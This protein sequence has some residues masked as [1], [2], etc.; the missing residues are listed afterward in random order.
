M[1]LQV[2]LRERFAGR[3][4]ILVGNASFQHDRSEFIDGHDIVVRFN[5]FARPDLNPAFRGQRIDYWFMNLTRSKA[6][7]KAR[8]EHLHVATKWNPGVIAVTP[9]ENDRED[10]LPAARRFFDVRGLTLVFPKTQV[11]TPMLGMRN[12]RRAFQPSTGFYTAF[13]LRDAGVPLTVIGFTG[14]VNHENHNGAAEIEWLKNQPGM[15]AFDA[16]F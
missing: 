15:I 6:D 11:A 14:C 3:S 8:A 13:R 12:A 1:D 2:F 16:C 10:R 9:H 7:R 4:V 5:S